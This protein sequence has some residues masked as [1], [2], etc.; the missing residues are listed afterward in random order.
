MS[1]SE[2]LLPCL[3]LAARIWPQNGVWPF[4]SRRKELAEVNRRGREELLL[5]Q[6]LFMAGAESVRAS[7]CR[8]CVGSRHQSAIPGLETLSRN[9]VILTELITPFASASVV[10]N[11]RAENSA[12]TTELDRI[13]HVPRRKGITLQEKEI[14]RTLRRIEG[15]VST[16]AASVTTATD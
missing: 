9:L 10:S 3:A 14:N 4:K 13:S 6:A 16:W 8:E 15:L 12:L 5:R 11:L 2:I 7:I 1:L